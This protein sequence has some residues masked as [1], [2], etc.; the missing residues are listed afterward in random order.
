MLQDLSIERTKI[1]EAMAFALDHA[2]LSSQVK[3]E[4]LNIENI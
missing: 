2:D 3:I 4:N 1:R